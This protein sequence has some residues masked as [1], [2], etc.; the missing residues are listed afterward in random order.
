MRIRE[1]QRAHSYNSRNYHLFEHKWFWKN[2]KKGMPRLPVG[3]SCG[4]TGRDMATENSL[5][6]MQCGDWLLMKILHFLLFHNLLLVDLSGPREQMHLS[7]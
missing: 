2:Y 4:H 5:R 6:L 3:V 1:Q 7:R